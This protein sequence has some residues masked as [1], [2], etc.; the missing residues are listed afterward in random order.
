MIG[1]LIKYLTQKAPDI[2]DEYTRNVDLQDLQ[3]FFVLIFSICTWS[4]YLL[5]VTNWTNWTT[6]LKLETWW[7]SL[8]MNCFAVTQV[9]FYVIDTS[10]NYIKKNRKHIEFCNFFGCHLGH[11]VIALSLRVIIIHFTQ[12]WGSQLLQRCQDSSRPRSRHRW[13]GVEM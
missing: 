10:Q 4:G 7:T 11:L 9:F 13:D 2:A 3:D 12:Y 5:E 1:V 8:K 6:L